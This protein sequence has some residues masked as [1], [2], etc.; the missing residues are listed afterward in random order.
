MGLRNCLDCVAAFGC[1]S[2]ALSH[3]VHLGRPSPSRECRERLGI[4]QMLT[5]NMSARRSWFAPPRSQAP[6]WERTWPWCESGDPAE[7]VPKWNLG[8][9]CPQCRSGDPTSVIPGG[10]SVIRHYSPI[11][12]LPH[13]HKALDAGVRAAC[14]A[15]EVHAARL[16]G[17]IPRRRVSAGLHHRAH[18]RCDFLS[19]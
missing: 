7:N 9:S 6:A 15:I 14:Q 4:V 5:K 16:G 17:C 3:L 1:P 19:K 8:T 2:S 12:C 11:D 13:Q 10:G 18:Q